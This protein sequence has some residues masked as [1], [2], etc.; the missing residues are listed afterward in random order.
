MNLFQ[1]LEYGYNLLKTNNINSYKIDAELLLSDSLNISKERLILNLKRVIN[2]ETYNNFLLKINRRKAKEPIAYILKKKE[3]W[4]NKFYINKNVLIP[5]PETEHL[6]EE[7][8]NIIST[9]QKKRLLEIGV[10]SGCLIISVLK[11]RI[12]CSAFGIDCCKN[13]IK[14]AK[15]NAKLHQ[16]ENRIKIFKSDV[17]NF[18]TGKYDLIISNPPY[19]DKHQLKNF[20]SIF[21]LM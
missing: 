8:L 5:R 20:N 11:E 3:F 16:V 1:A 14:I 15:I 19:I 17:D 4:K 13:A 2:N 18:I 10:G 21:N 6:V 7:T 12:N 9:N